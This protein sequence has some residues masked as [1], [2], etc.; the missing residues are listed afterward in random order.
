MNYIK[1]KCDAEK[2]LSSMFHDVHEGTIISKYKESHEIDLAT[3]SRRLFT[4]AILQQLVKRETGKRFYHWLKKKKQKTISEFT[5]VFIQFT[6]TMHRPM[7]A[8]VKWHM[9]FRQA[10][11]I[12]VKLLCLNV[13]ITPI[14]GCKH[15]SR[16]LFN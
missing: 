8:R 3:F 2:F 7:A 15:I 16:N 1:W 11:R 9:K 12:T 10:F 13:N 14:Q 6:T 4:A 5:V